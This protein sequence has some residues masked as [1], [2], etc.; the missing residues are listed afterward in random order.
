M[1]EPQNSKISVKQA[2]IENFAKNVPNIKI[3]LGFCGIKEGNDVHK[4]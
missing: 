3:S 2:K 1:A 4:Q